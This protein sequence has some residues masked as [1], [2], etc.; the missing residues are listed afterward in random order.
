MSFEGMAKLPR[1]RISCID[2]PLFSEND[3]GEAEVTELTMGVI[4]G[5]EIYRIIMDF[6]GSVT[7]GTYDL[8][9]GEVAVTISS[10]GLMAPFG[11]DTLTFESGT[12]TLTGKDSFRVK[13]K[14]DL[15]STGGQKVVI[16]FYSRVF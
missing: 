9:A 12:V 13:G 1:T 15:V 2:E 11:T 5:G 14:L 6:E 8:A 3:A 4:T 7:Q 10:P 16:D